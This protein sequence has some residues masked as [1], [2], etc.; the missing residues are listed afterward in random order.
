MT[1]PK[2]TNQIVANSAIGVTAPS[3]PTVIED[4]RT[5]SNVIET[6]SVLDPLDGEILVVDEAYYNR[7]REEFA[8]LDRMAEF[9]LIP[10]FA[11]ALSFN[12]IG[13]R[14]GRDDRLRGIEEFSKTIPHVPAGPSLMDQYRNKRTKEADARLEHRKRQQDKQDA[15]SAA[16]QRQKKARA[17]NRRHK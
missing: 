11:A 6:S 15:R 9:A 3:L 8:S 14:R 5:P 17:A 10:G 1:H 7:P 2:G 4:N 16:R 13:I 12:G